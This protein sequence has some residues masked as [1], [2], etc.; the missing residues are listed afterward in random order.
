VKVILTIFLTII[1]FNYLLKKEKYL[2]RDKT[3]KSI[4]RKRTISSIFFNEFPL[5]LW[6]TLNQHLKEMEIVLLTF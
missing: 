5:Y 3:V 1:S 6:K 2:E 4:T